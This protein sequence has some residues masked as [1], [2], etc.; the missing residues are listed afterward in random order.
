MASVLVQTMN[1]DDQPFGQL[2][3]SALTHIL[4]EGVNS[5]INDV[6]FDTYREDSIKNTERSNRGSTRPPGI[7]FRNMALGGDPAMENVSQQLAQHDQPHKV[8]G[9]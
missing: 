4:H 8:P 5:H 1:G 2:A 6:V 7:L 3:E 9:G